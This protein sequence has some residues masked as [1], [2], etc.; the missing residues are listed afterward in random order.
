M[1]KRQVKC[2]ISNIDMTYVFNCGRIPTNV[3]IDRIDSAKGYI[4]NNIQLVCMACNQMKSDLSE[5]KLYEFCKAIV[6]NYES[7]NNKNSQ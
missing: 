7:K 5:H 6:N 1:L 3:S 4:M 2:A